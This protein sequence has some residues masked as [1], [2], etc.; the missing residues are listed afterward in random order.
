MNFF[1]HMLRD[2]PVLTG[3]FPLS[4]IMEQHA[5]YE[6]G[7]MPSQDNQQQPGEALPLAFNTTKS[8]AVV[9]VGALDL[10][11]SSS[12]SGPSGPMP[13]DQTRN[14][15]DLSAVL[16]G[17]PT[18]DGVE[19]PPPPPAEPYENFL[20]RTGRLSTASSSSAPQPAAVN[21]TR[22]L[23]T[24]PSAL[25]RSF[26]TFEGLEQP[27]RAPVPAPGLG[28]LLPDSCNVPPPDPWTWPSPGPVLPP[29]QS[30]L[31]VP[32]MP[33]VHAGAPRTFPDAVARPPGPLLVLMTP[34]PSAKNT[35]SYPPALGPI[36]PRMPRPLSLEPAGPAAWSA[37]LPIQPDLLTGPPVPSAMV[38]VA[39]TFATVP[40]SS[41]VVAM[42][43]QV[44]P[45][46]SPT[47]PNVQDWMKDALL[48][49][50]QTR[51]SELS[52]NFQR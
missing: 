15:P 51:W 28:K 8:S 32:G 33:P 12:S 24:L 17:P 27:P 19:Q 26:P 16:T 9:P 11:T 4:Y 41:Q 39:T 1:I 49:R 21:V 5:A 45:V 20:R 6:E 52:L 14:L 34:G 46:P 42:P 50:Y 29:F 37:P 22:D 2:C 43:S 23:V 3:N 31:V 38:S 13:E 10:P 36:F 18:L 30:P 7:D 44:L 35:I 47:L 25:P 48:S 40:P